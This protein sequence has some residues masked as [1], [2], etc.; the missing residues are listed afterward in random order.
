MFGIFRNEIDS[1]FDDAAARLF[2]E[3]N[4]YDPDTEEYQN[5]LDK[6]ERLAK[7]NENNQRSKVSADTIAIVA[8]NLLGI[9]IVVGYERGH[10]LTTR[11]KDFVLKPK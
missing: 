11:M 10:V 3:M 5:A 2:D 9:L 1:R 6:L 4:T 8:G 7:I